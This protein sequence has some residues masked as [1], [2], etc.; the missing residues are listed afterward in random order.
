MPPLTGKPFSAESW[1]KAAHFLFSHRAVHST[2]LGRSSE[3]LLNG[4]VM[5]FLWS[6]YTSDRCVQLSELVSLCGNSNWSA[7]WSR[8]LYSGKNIDFSVEG[9]L[10]FKPPWCNRET[11]NLKLKATGK[12][13]GIPPFRVTENCSGV[14]LH[15]ETFYGAGL[16]FD[17][18]AH[19]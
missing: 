18:Q 10:N 17:N 5:P 2:F 12:Q 13:R 19:F 3:S 4:F 7:R 11:G 9:N 1:G 6:G 8:S 16:F 15:R 14:R